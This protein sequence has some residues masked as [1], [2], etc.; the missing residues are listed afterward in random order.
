MVAK[1]E[2]TLSAPVDQHKQRIRND[3]IHSPDHDNHAVRTQVSKEARQ[4]LV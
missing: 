4:T 3:S 2:L 1:T